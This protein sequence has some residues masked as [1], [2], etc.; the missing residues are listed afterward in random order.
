MNQIAE[1]TDHLLARSDE[2]AHLRADAAAAENRA[3]LERKEIE[4]LDL[5]MR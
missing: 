5:E 1:T 2:L 4:R 3:Y